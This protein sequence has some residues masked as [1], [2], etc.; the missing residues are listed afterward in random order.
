[1]TCAIMQPTYWPWVGGFDL[2]DQVD[3]YVHY[4]DVQVVKRSWDVRNRIKTA[5]GELFL[6]VPIR[7][8]QHRDSTLF[9]NAQIDD[10]GTWRAQHL[11]SI[12]ASY[13]KAPFFDEVFALV[14]PLLMAKATLL[15]EFNVSCISAIA[16]SIG[17]RTPMVRSS[18]LQATTGKK[19]ARLLSICQAVMADR[20]VSPL[21]AHRYIEA[22]NPGGAF[23]HSGVELVYQNYCPEPYRQLHGAFLSHMCILDLLFNEGPADSLSIIRKGRRAPL[24]SAALGEGAPV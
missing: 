20:Y 12:V 14:E 1:M 22:D 6:T 16:E 5:R 15:G 23:Q 17:I 8:T 21:G 2:M 3:V 4:D 24:S 7:K 11:K 19:D 10:S 18:T 13:R 9:T